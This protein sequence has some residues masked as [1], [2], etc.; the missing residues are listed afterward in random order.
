MCQGVDGLGQIGLSVTYEAKHI[1]ILLHGH[2]GLVSGHEI[3]EN[4]GKKGEKKRAIKG[5][6]VINTCNIDSLG[7]PG[8]V[9]KKLKDIYE[10]SKLALDFD[11]VKIESPCVPFVERK[12]RERGYGDNAKDNDLDD[13]NFG[14][15]TLKQLKERCKAKKRKASDVVWLSPKQE[16][17]HLEPE[18]DEF[19]LMEPLSSLKSKLSKSPKTKKKCK[20]RNVSSKIVQS[21]KSEQIL[22]DE[23]PLQ[24]SGHFPAPTADKAEDPGPEYSES[25]ITTCVMDGSSGCIEHVGLSGAESGEVIKAYNCEL[26]NGESIFFTEQCGS[27]VV[28]SLSYDHLEH[29][30]HASLPSPIHGETME[31]D[32]QEKMGQESPVLHVPQ[33]EEG[34]STKDPSFHE[35]FKEVV[36]PAKDQQSHMCNISQSCSDSEVQ[37]SS[38]SIDN[39]PCRRGDLLENLPPNVDNCSLSSPFSNCSSSL[40]SNPPLSS[41][42][43]LVSEND[44]SLTD[45]KQPSVISPTS[46]ERLCLAMKSVEVFDDIDHYKCKEKLF[47]RQNDGKTSPREIGGADLS[48]SPKKHAQVVWTKASMTP[49]EILKKPKNLKKGSPPKGCL[50]GP[51]LSRSFPRLS[52]GCTSI[53]GCS[54]SA[55]AF[56]QRQMHDIESLATKLMSELKSVKEIVEEKLLYEAYRSTSLKNDAD[57][58]KKV[59]KNVTKVE[60]TSRK[61]LSMMSRDCNRF[62]KIMRLTENDAAAASENPIQREKKITFADEAGGTL[63]QVKLFEN[64][65][66][67][68]EPKSE[69]H[70]LQQSE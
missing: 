29:V 58:V 35:S 69:T 30:E 42:N 66:A 28:N 59:I 48:L 26:E 34:G 36:S 2:S 23:D 12:T 38:A 18:E 11:G 70:E 24:A 60:E 40:N 8:L 27:C 67:S 22:G 50:E 62:C 10:D 33:F 55:I 52:T 63:C 45:E 43:S 32:N 68:M 5:G 1:S 61:W 37:V 4:E 9:F 51:H 57:E 16:C 13:L 31:V 53:Q 19:D 65:M 20:G 41:D 54:E 3:R 56:S 64:G 21:I 14:K 25:Q 47:G 39:G 44:S 15:M 49:K 6:L 7:R 17:T 46:Q